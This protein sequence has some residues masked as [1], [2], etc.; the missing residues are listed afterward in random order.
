MSETPDPA[1]S[2]E[3]PPFAP[4]RGYR[5]LA[6][7]REA[8]LVLA[9]RELVHRIDRQGEEWV[10]SVD[11]AARELAEEELTAFEA[12]QA[13]RTPAPGSRLIAQADP[14]SLLLV[15]MILAGAFIAQERMGERLLAAGNAES[16]AIVGR[17]EW[18]RCFTALLLHADLGHLV[19]NLGFGLLFTAFLIPQVGAGLTWFLV[20]LAG[21]AGNALN[22]WG[23]RGEPHRSI[24]AST[25]VFAALGLL[26]GSE[27]Y[28][29]WAFPATR[30]RRH[31][32]APLGA[33]LALLAILGVGEKHE[34]IDFMAHAWGFFSGVLLALP[35]GALLAR[36]APPPW[37]Q[38]AAG[39]CALGVVATAWWIALRAS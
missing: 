11:A 25:A 39:L 15:G 14:W 17:G 12:E 27:L 7:A 8:A 2:G 19:A 16:M 31:L 18:W 21:G 36:G 4:V 38:R 3:E 37:G 5:K 29:R 30:T 10:L 34:R 20:V 26:V 32:I 22:A 23:Y 1:A 13:E 6:Q 24:G 33:G 28:A 35:V 9:A